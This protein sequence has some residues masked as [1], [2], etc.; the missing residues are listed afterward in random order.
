[1]ALVLLISYDPAQYF[2]M[3]DAVLAADRDGRLRAATL[4]RSARRL[5]TAGAG[6]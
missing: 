5:A 1:M 4:A 3:M 6:R 2:A